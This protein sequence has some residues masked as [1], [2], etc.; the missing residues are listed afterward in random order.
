VEGAEGHEAEGGCTS[1]M[2]GQE[3]QPDETPRTAS[4]GFSRHEPD[5]DG[6]SNEASYLMDI[7]PVH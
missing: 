2:R 4:S 5:A 1:G 3:A 7:Q 6:I